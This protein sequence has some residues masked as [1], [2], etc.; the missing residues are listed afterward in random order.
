MT[1]ALLLLLCMPTAVFADTGNGLSTG[2]GRVLFAEADKDV[3][4]DAFA[5]TVEMGL[6]GAVVEGK[7]MPVTVTVGNFSGADVSGTLRSHFRGPTAV[8]VLP[9]NGR[10]RFRTAVKRV[11]HFC[12]QGWIQAL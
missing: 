5:V 7:S 10:L 1:T 3:E 4:N 11:F 12:F 8:T 2:S 9:M 6:D